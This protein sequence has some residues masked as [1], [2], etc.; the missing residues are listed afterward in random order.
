MS[1]NPLIADL[2][3]SL[4]FSISPYGKVAD[5]TSQT[6][7]WAD[8]VRSVLG[9]LIGERVM[10]P[11]FGSR[12]PLEVFETSTVAVQQVKEAVFNAFAEFLPLLTLVS[13]NV[14]FDDT[15][16][17]ISAEVIYSLPNQE[18]VTTNIGVLTQIGN[19]PI[20]EELV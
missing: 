7:V 17:L 2:A 13:V 5:T 12:I 15:E 1:K 19:A 3:I 11:R 8:R 9:T 20:S 14:T 4:P 16:S 18:T 10:R 6:K